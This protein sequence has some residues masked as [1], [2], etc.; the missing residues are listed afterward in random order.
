MQPKRKSRCWDHVKVISIKGGKD[1][2]V[3]CR[4]GRL[5]L[6][7]FIQIFDSKVQSIDYWRENIRW[8]EDAAGGGEIFIESDDEDTSQSV[9]ECEDDSF[10]A[11]S[12]GEFECSGSDSEGST[13]SENASDQA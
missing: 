9:N 2:R 12:G 13:A 11:S 10:C 7:M 4:K 5:I 1:R 6:C 3:E 8:L